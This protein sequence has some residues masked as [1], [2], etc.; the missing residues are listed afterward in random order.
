MTRPKWAA[1][2]PELLTRIG[3]YAVQQTAWGTWGTP[4][5]VQA[6]RF[7]AVCRTF[8]A[9]VLASN[10]WDLEPPVMLHWRLGTVPVSA[11]CLLSHWAPQFRFVSLTGQHEW[12]DH[13][14]QPRI[15]RARRSVEGREVH[16]TV[17]T[18]QQLADARVLTTCLTIADQLGL[19]S[20][21]RIVCR[22]MSPAEVQLLAALRVT[23]LYLSCS[24]G[25]V[26][27]A[28]PAA[29]STEV[30][31]QYHPLQSLTG[32]P[33]ELAWHAMMAASASFFRF[34]S[35]VSVQGYCSQGP[36][37]SYVEVC[38]NRSYWMPR[39]SSLAWQDVHAGHDGWQSVSP[40]ADPPDAM[41][42]RGT[43]ER[44][45]H[46]ARGPEPSAQ[47]VWQFGPGRWQKEM[48]G[49]ATIGT[50]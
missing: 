31:V 42:W 1:L 19:C 43:H 6:T 3:Q 46:Y 35:P 8:R 14:A 5:L 45:S 36:M 20:K 26:L 23:H 44:W 15:A 9:A 34:A 27:D 41:H 17:D 48:F 7:A 13:P 22:D 16:I 11:G 29:G 32:P 40:P 33:L 18:S 50:A 10:F 49:K 39:S 37:T 28:L 12:P 47:H 2:L 30:N 21:V 4:K 25:F 38:S 24:A